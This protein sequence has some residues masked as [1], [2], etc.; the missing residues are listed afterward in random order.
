MRTLLKRNHEPGHQLAALMIPT[1]IA[2]NTGLG[3]LM[4][5]FGGAE[6][7]KAAVTADLK[8][9]QPKV[10][11]CAGRE[12][13]GKYFY[14]TRLVSLLAIFNEFK[15]SKRPDVSPEEYRAYQA[16]KYDNNM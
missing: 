7:Y 5:P 9:I 16:F 13:A 11:Q 12:V 2:I 1:G 10:Q 6:G 8:K 15:E 4:S 3:L 14:G